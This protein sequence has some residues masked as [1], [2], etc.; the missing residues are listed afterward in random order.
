MSIETLLD[1]SVIQELRQRSII[2]Q[3][4][5]AINSGDLY[6]AKNVLTNEKRM[7]EAST[8][9]SLNKNESFVDDYNMNI[10]GFINDLRN[11]INK[12][13]LPKNFSILEIKEKNLVFAVS[14][15][16]VNYIKPLFLDDVIKVTC[17][18]EKISKTSINFVQKITN[19][20]D[21]DISSALC[22]IV[23]LNE[24]FKPTKIPD[25][26]ADKIV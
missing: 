26:I 4:E 22:K 16:N 15:I 6:Y 3:E 21:I 5:V 24:N 18:I 2:S 12:E 13:Q 11:S 23:C 20:D 7:L 14:E 17:S 25:V 9:T 19:Q 1:S 10:E 8:I